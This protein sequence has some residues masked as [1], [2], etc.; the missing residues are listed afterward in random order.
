M[1]AR[2][3]AP[4]HLAAFVHGAAEDD[5]VWAGKIDV[6]E[7]ALLER[8][9]WREVNG[10]DAGFGDA[11]HF[12]GFDVADVLGV[13][14]IE[15]GSFRGNEPGIEAAGGSEFAE[16]ERTE[17]A[18]I[19]HGVEFVFC[20]DEKR[21]RGFDLIEGVTDRAGKIAGLRAGNEMD[22][23]F[24]VAVGRENRAAM[25]ELAAPLGGVGKVAVVAEGNFALVAIDHDG[26]GVEQSFVACGGV[27]RVT[28]RKAAG[29]LRKDAWLEDF[30]DFAHRAVDVQFFAVARDNARGFL[31]TMLEGVETEVGKVGSFGV[32]EDAEDTTFVVEVIVRNGANSI[33]CRPESVAKN[34]S[35]T[36]GRNSQPRKKPSN[37]AVATSHQVKPVWR[38][39][40]IV[41]MDVVRVSN[42]HRILPHLCQE[43]KPQAT[44]RNAVARIAL[45]TVSGPPKAVSSRK[46]NSLTRSCAKSRTIAAQSTTIASFPN[47]ATGFFRPTPSPIIEKTNV[48]I[49]QSSAAPEGD[50]KFRGSSKNTL[51]ALIKHAA[52]TRTAITKIDHRMVSK[53]RFISPIKYA[54]DCLPR[55]RGAIQWNCRSPRVPYVRCGTNRRG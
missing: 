41:P 23:D 52:A 44:K 43:C 27:A 12:A 29:E 38:K 42:K 28:D 21:V 5:A 31:A 8:L 30:F 50:P 2:E 1:L 9:F 22:A 26:L 25:V 19:A 24:G 17:A 40:T 10:L 32:A 53:E 18:R 45:N 47:C 14:Q 4:E 13:E 6:L 33:H 54:R 11:Y 20:E 48:P 3:E 36:N 15:S 34:R 39:I 16:N 35:R 55:R 37:T 46:T 49:I 51:N 7:N